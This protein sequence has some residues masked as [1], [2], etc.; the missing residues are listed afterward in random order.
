MVI[1]AK[2]GNHGLLFNGKIK[3]IGSI[4][5]GKRFD[6]K[7]QIVCYQKVILNYGTEFTDIFYF[8]NNRLVYSDISFQAENYISE[9]YKSLILKGKVS[10]NDFLEGLLEVY[11]FKEMGF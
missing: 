8:D 4:I 7:G 1:Y 10:L 3:V 11:V 5:D 6:L 2:S 9:T